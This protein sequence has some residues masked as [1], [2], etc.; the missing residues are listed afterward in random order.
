MEADAEMDVEVVD[1]DLEVGFTSVTFP[2]TIHLPVPCAQQSVGSRSSCPPWQHQDLS[3]HW[4]TFL[5]PAVH[6]SH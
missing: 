5:S 2:L 6:A 1:V 3:W 4:K